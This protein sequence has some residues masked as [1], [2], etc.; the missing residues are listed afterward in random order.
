MQNDEQGRALPD[1]GG[2]HRARSSKVSVLIVEDELI[3]AKSI[4]FK[5]RSMGYAV[6][7]IL[8]SGEEAV[9]RAEALRP[10]LVL[11]DIGL[12]GAMDGIAAAERIC[13]LLDIPVVYLTAYSDQ[14]TLDRAKVSDPFGYLT[15]PFDP[16]DLR[17][18][19]EMAL[20]KYKAD[21]RLRE[22]EARYRAISELTSDLAY[23]LCIHADGSATCEWLA[24]A[25]ERIT[26][27]SLDEK[28]VHDLL[29]TMIHPDDAP[30]FSQHMQEALAGR[31]VTSEGRI[32]A[33]DGSVRWLRDVSQPVWDEAEG[34]VVRVY[35]AVQDVTARKEAEEALRR[36]NEELEQRV[37]ERTAE[38]LQ[39]NE[40]LRAE[41]A[42]RRW[43][44]EAL[45]TSEAEHRRLFEHAEAALAEVNALY[46]VSRVLNTLDDLPG[47]LDAVARQ[48]AETLPADEVSILLLDLEQ[49]TVTH[50][51]LAGTGAIADLEEI[52]F[53]EL[54]DGLT[55]WV[56]R[57]GQPVISPAS[58][59]DERE[60]AYVRRRREQV[61]ADAVAVVP[62]RYRDRMLGTMTAIHVPGGRDW[63]QSDVDLMMAMANQIAVAVENAR[64]YELSRGER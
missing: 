44:E 1:G 19:I 62:V 5:L 59:P 3:V 4:E 20:F 45:R 58:A 38:L 46:Q 64:L 63:T 61:N 49:R 55:G 42:A 10:D 31:P 23:A 25:V 16:K 48:V 6:P 2:E 9:E 47:M 54:E 12:H 29:A 14:A 51:A 28:G 13:A 33:R 8:M 37:R 26:G 30:A 39:A 17:A 56:L 53:E 15:K 57:E 7:A 22:S 41:G 24:G 36:A 34:R 35:G 32:M 11:M 50:S 27:Y 52:T 21:R 40:S 18:T 43:V 60:S